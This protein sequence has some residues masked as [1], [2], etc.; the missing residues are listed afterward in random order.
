[1]E[2]PLLKAL[3]RYRQTVSAFRGYN[4]NDRIGDGEFAH[5]ENMT[6]DCYPLLSPRKRRGSYAAVAASGLIA[7]DSLCHV[8]GSRFVMNG[9]GVD[10]GLSQ[11]EKQLVGMGAYVI[12]LP[13][14]KYI[15]TR[16][17][18]DWG[19]LDARFTTEGKVKLTLCNA[20]GEVYSLQHAP[21]A[22]EPA[23]PQNLDLWIDTAQ[24]PHVLKQW[25]EATGL[26]VRVDS[27]YVRIENPGLGKAFSQY[28]GITLSGL[29]A[30]EAAAL[31]GSAVVWQKG[32]DYIVVTGLLDKPL[33][34]DTPVT[35][36]RAMPEM[37]FVVESENRLWGCR[38]GLDAQGRV[39]NELYASKLGDFKNWRCYM[40]L[41]TDSYA[42]SLGSDGP[43][44]G[45][46]THLGY[47]IFF[48]EHCMHKVYGNLPENFQVQTTACRG[49][50]PGCHRSLAVV[51]ETLFYKAT[52]GIWPMM[53]ACPGR[54][55]RPWPGRH[56]KGRPPARWTINTMC[57]WLTVRGS[58]SFWCTIRP[59]VC[60]T[61]RT[62]CM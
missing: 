19:D 58:G 54:S 28:D 32:E 47:P 9:Y 43:F 5:M 42:A 8:E 3:R 57:P 62:A 33:E 60:G 53:A 10:M 14:K 45:A 23:S 61:G 21:G 7:K 59:G 49:V 56:T 20:E 24:S 15:N 17:L 36:E 40:G 27:T 37:D 41:S 38:Y 1:M 16:D 12:I 35:A 11:G 46:V 44:T 48:K 31:E 39:V 25:S 4:R 26:W 52:G 50:Q 34:L 18:T 2:Y 22:G 30:T 51:G 6:S 13:D 29:G 55:A